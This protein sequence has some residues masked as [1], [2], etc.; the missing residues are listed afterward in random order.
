MA[1]ED[2]SDNDSDNTLE[3]AQELY[4]KLSAKNSKSYQAAKEDQRF[5]SG[6]Q[7]DTKDF[8]SRREANRPTLTTN[9]LPQ[10]VHQV[11]NEIR[12]NTPQIKVAPIDDGGTVAEA[13]IWQGLIRSIEKISNADI[14]YDTAVENAVK[15]SFGFIR[16]DH[17]Y[18][19]PD[20]FEQHILIKS[21]ENPLS[22]VIDGI[23]PDGSDT[24]HA[25]VLDSIPKEDFEKQFPNKDPVSFGDNTKHPAGDDEDVIIAEYFCLKSED[26]VI[27][28]LEDGKT[29]Y[30]DDFINSGQPKELIKATRTIQKNTVKRQKLSGADILEETTFPGS[31]IPIVPVYGAIQWIDG[32]RQLWSLIRNAKD[33]QRR[34]NYFASAE[35]ESISKAPQAPFTAFEGQLEGHEDEWR[36]PHKVTV[37]QHIPVHDKNGT[38]L[39]APSRL[40]P[41]QI[42]TGAV[43]A[44]AE[45]VEDMKASMGL[46][47]T[48]LGKQDNASSGLAIG[49]RKQQ[50]EVATFHFGDNLIRSI[51]QC[52]K[53]IMSMIPEVYDTQRI[54]RVSHPDDKEEMVEINNGT[55]FSTQANKYDVTVTT[56]PSFDTRREETQNMIANIMQTNQQLVPLIGDLFFKY[57]DVPG[58]EA[59]SAR[60]KKTLPPGLA[61]PEDGQEAQDPEKMQLQAQLQEMQAQMQQMAAELQ[62]KQGEL[63]LKMQE[64][65]LKAAELKLQEMELQIESAKARG[66]HQ[67]EQSKEAFER[68]I[69]EHGAAISAY[70]AETRRLA[71]AQKESSDQRK[72][73]QANIKLDTTG[74][75]F[76]KTPEQEAMDAEEKQ[77]LATKEQEAQ[78]AA[79]IEKQ[80]SMQMQQ[81]I[82]ASLQSISD[83]L[84]I[85]NNAMVQQTQAIAAPKAVMRDP[86]TGLIVGIQ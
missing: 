4:Q 20:K 84:K 13:K 21:V 67:N 31:Y 56:G 15:S 60:L 58:A 79:A 78:A 27:F 47:N 72:Q 43:N 45:A 52:G 29:I 57:S 14:A 54:I 51:T 11:V 86:S 37:L 65:Q 22:V 36:N 63:Q 62:N 6:D 35:I 70:D 32:E 50:G 3:E 75:Q 77:M 33:A 7:W 12:M 19:A 8:N 68:K 26:K 46:Y 83:N 1:Y 73:E 80:A 44:K 2:D 71:L 76:S 34:I 59:I 81:L 38:L 25:F 53:V 41:P 18:I 69:K 61:E 66:E 49:K 64:N 48:S 5:Y 82:L 17:D 28:Q 42:P 30:A 9:H 24:K 39:P 74:F 10:F 55:I 85:Q 23:K 40:Q 16:I